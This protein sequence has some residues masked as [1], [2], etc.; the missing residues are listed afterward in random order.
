MDVHC[1]TCGEAWD[2]HHLRHGAIWETDFSDEEIAE[3]NGLSAEERL[4]EPYRGQ[5]RRAGYEFGGSIF[6]LVRCAACPPDSKPDPERLFIKA[7][8]ESLLFGDE[9]ALAAQYSELGL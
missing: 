5:L 3:W 2:T 6:N 1:T 7:E 4:S 8:I 9:D